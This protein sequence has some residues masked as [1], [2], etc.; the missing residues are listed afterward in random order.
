MN[1]IK[2]TPISAICAATNVGDLVCL[3]PSHS[4]LSG[5]RTTGVVIES[6]SHS[7]LVR[8]NDGDCVRSQ[9]TALC[10]IAKGN[11]DEK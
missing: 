7:S 3:V 10:I 11:V 5:W 2:S 8:W 1:K 4:W 6:Q 9:N